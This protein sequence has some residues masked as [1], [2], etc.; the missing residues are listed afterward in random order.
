MPETR[1]QL[2]KLKELTPQTHH[3]NDGIFLV[4]EF[5]QNISF[6]NPKKHTEQAIYA[7][8]NKLELRKKSSPEKIQHTALRS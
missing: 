4:L 7:V 8:Y 5:Q 3:A 6:C 2:V 1:K